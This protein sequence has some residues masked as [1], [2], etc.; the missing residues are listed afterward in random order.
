MDELVI[1]GSGSLPTPKLAARLIELEGTMSADPPTR[2]VLAD[3]SDACLAAA[4]VAAK[5][6]ISVV[7]H[8]AA[9]EGS[10]V[11]SRLIAQLA[12]TYTAPA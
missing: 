5:L 6:G 2:V 4:L 9:S 12:A 3:D 11:S 8:R 10:S 7:A 1:E